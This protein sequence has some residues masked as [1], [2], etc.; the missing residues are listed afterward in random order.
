MKPNKTNTSMS[1]ERE[2]I[3]AM[4]EYLVKAF[5]SPQAFQLTAAYF[6]PERMQQTRLS[7]ALHS[8]STYRT[9]ND[10]NLFRA[11]LAKNLS[12]PSAPQRDGMLLLMGHCMLSQPVLQASKSCKS[13][14]SISIP[15]C[16]FA[17]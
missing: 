11:T 1:S 17:A 12:Q 2:V 6:F 4:Q 15:S 5:P 7:C 3:R 13:C 9:Q 8:A 14:K 10:K 16:V